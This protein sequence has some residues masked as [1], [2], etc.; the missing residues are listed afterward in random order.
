[1][2]T[3]R[4]RRAGLRRHARGHWLRPPARDRPA[5]ARERVIASTGLAALDSGL[6]RRRRPGGRGTPGQ[7]GGGGGG[8]SRGGLGVC[9]AASKGAPGE[10][11]GIAYL[12][13]DRLTALGVTFTLGPPGK[14]GIRCA[15]F[16]K[17]WV[18]ARP[19]PRNVLAISGEVRA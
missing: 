17:C 2:R 19:C 10:S 7:C 9:G 11:F 5:A 3:S 16:L 18:G 1:M 14:S 13:E 12:D 8:R 4:G 15:D 6:G